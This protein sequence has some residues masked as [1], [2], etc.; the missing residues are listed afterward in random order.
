MR[1]V[2]VLC[3]PPEE[4]VLT[5]CLN[6]LHALL[7]GGDY[8]DALFLMGPAAALAQEQ[9]HS[10]PKDELIAAAAAAAFPL[11]VCGRAAAHHGVDLNCL[12]APFVPGGYFQLLAAMQEAE[13]T[14]EI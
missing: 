8:V 11:Y 9:L 5:E 6:L 2:M 4:A 7:K 1:A 3:R 14:I 12:A 10:A 13:R